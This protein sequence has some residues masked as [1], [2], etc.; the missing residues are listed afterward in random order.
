MSSRA[1][2]SRIVR[3]LLAG[4]LPLLVGLA[5]FPAHAQFGKNKVQY[6][7]FDWYTIET[8]H[9]DIYYYLE[10][11]ESARIAARMAERG[12]ERLSRILNHEIEDRIPVIVYA[13]HS[14]FQQTNIT[15]GLISE[16][17]GGITEFAKRRVFLPFTGSYGEFDHVLVHELVHAF[18]VDLMYSGAAGNPFAFQPPLW[19]ME[20]MAE[21][22]S[23]GGVDPNTE[24]WLRWS[25]LEGQL[26]P[27]HYMDRVYDIRVYRIGQAIFDFVGQRFGDEKIGQLLKATFAHQSAN[28]A[29]TKTLGMDLRELNDEWEDYVKRKYYPQIVDLRRPE[30]HARR[31]L[32]Q[33]G[34]AA[35]H[36]APS[37]SPQGDRVVYIEDAR[38][39]T[40]IE[41]ASALDGKHLG[42]L[43]TGARSGDFES[44]RYMYTAIGWSPDGTRIAFPSKKGGGDVLNIL[45]VDSR[46]VIHTIDFEFDALYSPAYHP[47]GRRV[48]FTGIRGGKSDLF[49]AT[50]DTGELVQIT[51]DPY[52]ARDPQFS[53][54][55][56]Q[57]A[58][59]T[60]RGEETDLDHLLFGP[61][62]VALLEMETG[63]IR[64]LSGQVG[65]SIA[66]QWGP[67]GDHIAFVSDRDGISDLYI[68]DLRTDR[69]H[70]LTNLITGVTGLIESSPPF[71]WSRDGER[72]VFTTFMGSGWELYSIDDPMTRMEEVET[73]EPLDRIASRE[74]ESLVPWE[75]PALRAPVLPGTESTPIPAPAA[76]VARAEEG[77]A[78]ESADGESTP[79]QDASR[80]VPADL[81]DLLAP[82]AAGL[83]LAGAGN[84]GVAPGTASPQERE[85]R[86]ELTLAHVIRE[87]TYELPDP[88]SLEGKPYRL[89]WSPDFVGAS[90]F[91]ASNVGFAGSAAIAI[92]DILS[93]H[94]IQIGASI[95]GSIDESDLFLGYYNLENRTNWGAAAFQYRNDFG[96][97]TA[98][99]RIGFESQIYRGVQTF[100]SRPFSKFSRVEFVA[101]GVGV[102]RSVVEQSFNSGGFVTTDEDDQG[103]EYYAGPEVALVTDNVVWGY[104]GPVHGH[105]ARLSSDQAFGDL[106]FNTTIGDYRR[107]VPL[108]SMVWA[109][110]LIGG[111]S[112]G[113]TPQLFGVGGPYTLRGLGY[114]ELRGENL[115]LL[116]TEFRFPL[117][118]TLRLGWPLRLALGGIG[119]VVFF[120]AGAAFSDNAR[121]MRDG[122]M[123][124]LGA[125]YGFGL[126]LGLGYFALKY[127]VGWETDLKRSAKSPREYFTI[128]V[129][130]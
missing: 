72:I 110:R 93:N 14:D 15:S 26:I 20:G 117:V 36:V 57:V 127:D 79:D 24:M 120:D 104:T 73:L 122:R 51:D 130:F 128:G 63:E 90:P 32:S 95:Y 11:E 48:I 8:E 100:V 115:A 2:W 98:E 10:E 85:A 35:V 46:K 89:R 56:K 106:Q 109:T 31:L 1:P 54:D 67:R 70:R 33:E 71:S 87:T 118:E 23:I 103:M 101:R 59:V 30:D 107:Y 123:E 114:G 7:D 81:S 6:K 27:L 19:F 53:P 17:T 61:P 86:P 68:Q 29:F 28:I 124:D 9:F 16:G 129:D 60:D 13:S 126:R 39:S 3:L 4:F 50:L 119:G 25:A 83:S 92:S 66:P 74:R 12:Y 41:L 69:L 82:P 47:D 76:V 65:K 58:F 91:F 97:F 88:E 55:G 64:L 108:G 49:M 84:P 34:F 112:N 21:Y 77:G 78:V 75:P 52:L 116:N 105:R 42:T 113:R 125:G 111:S 18:Q 102:S 96:I 38:F 22:L 99:D 94:V 5:A 37:I 121:L 43:V 44:L 62:R 40:D 45:D 80:P